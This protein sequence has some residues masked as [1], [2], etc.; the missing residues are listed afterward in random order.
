MLCPHRAGAGGC[1]VEI[2]RTFARSP[3]G[4][5]NTSQGRPGI[6][7]EGMKAVSCAKLAISPLRIGADQ[8]EIIR[9]RAQ[10]TADASA[11]ASRSA[12]E[13]TRWLS[14]AA[15]RDP[16]GQPSALVTAAGSELGALSKTL[17]KA[18]EVLTRAA[19]LEQRVGGAGALLE[20][21]ID[22]IRRLVDS[23]LTGTL[24]DLSALPKVI[25]SL[26]DYSNIFAPGL[27]LSTTMANKVDA[28]KAIKGGDVDV[29]AES[30]AID[31]DAAPL[32][33]ALDPVARLAFSLGKLRANAS[34]LARSV[35]QLRRK[36]HG[37]QASEIAA[38]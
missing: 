6:Y 11:K 22:E 10:A 27:N 3:L 18:N 13:V 36:G 17:D 23:A 37:D 5:W 8:L 26:S 15:S 28:S 32:A 19:S 24:S 21:H 12:G 2:S 34:I 31:G 29:T 30:G 38:G 25:G 20:T 4:S 9:Q 33:K 35:S 16:A 14:I 1:I 7:V